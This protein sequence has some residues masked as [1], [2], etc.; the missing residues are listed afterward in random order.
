MQINLA[1]ADIVD[2][3]KQKN[4]VADGDLKRATLDFIEE[5]KKYDDNPKV[6]K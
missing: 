6:V 1:L 4:I 3:L 2:V 5:Q